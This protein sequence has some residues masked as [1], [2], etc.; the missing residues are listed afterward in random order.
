MGLSLTS[1][2]WSRWRGWYT[3]AVMAEPARACMLARDAD[4]VY[5]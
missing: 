5:E 4:N 2:G 3:V 1:T